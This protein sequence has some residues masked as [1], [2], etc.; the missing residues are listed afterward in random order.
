ML[1]FCFF[2]N[3]ML[4]ESIKQEI[5]KILSSKENIPDDVIKA[6]K[7]VVCKIF[8]ICEDKIKEV[9]WIERKY[10]QDNLVINHCLLKW[11]Y[12]YRKIINNKQ[13]NY[14]KIFLINSLI[15]LFFLY[16]YNKRKYINKYGKNNW[17]SH[18]NE[19]RV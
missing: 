9:G 15:I 14:E 11:F 2:E 10:K 8:D 19:T 6:S 1:P 13:I 17:D 3:Y 16:I 12:K 5:N 4:E 7:E 18:K